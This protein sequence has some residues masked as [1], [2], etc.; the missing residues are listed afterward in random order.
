MTHA[1]I[2]AVQVQDLVIAYG[3]RTVL[4]GAEFTVEQGAI[5]A[6]IGPNGSGKTSLVKVLLGIHPPAAGTV[7][8]FGS[9][10][11]AVE[12]SRIGYVPQIKTMERHFPARAIELVVSGLRGRWP[13]RIRPDEQSRVLPA[14]DRVG[15]AHLADRQ[16]AQLSG[17]EL[18]RV[19]LAR[20]LIGRPELVLLDEPEAGIDMAGA[21]D[22]YELLE[23]YQAESGATIM[24]VTH[25]WNVAY[26]HATHALILNREQISFGPSQSALSERNL[27]R[28]FGH[29]GHAHAMFQT[30]SEDADGD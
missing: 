18:Q 28:A 22:L 25:D 9:E 17:G 12:R 13:A 24:M 6:I 11:G 29:V 20:C 2:P 23:E 1:S 14:L 8:I 26:H 27:R 16:L 19:Y 30:S 3:K 4:H 5:V 7:R 10:P 21:A 15:A